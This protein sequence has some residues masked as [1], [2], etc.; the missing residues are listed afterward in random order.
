MSAFADF[1]DL[2]TAVIEHVGRPDIAEVFPRLVLLAEAGFNRRLRLRDQITSTSVT[3]SSGSAALPSDYL[4]AIGLY[5]SNGL[6]YIQ[7]PIQNVKDTATKTKSYYA[8]N[9][10]NIVTKAADGAKTFEYY[11]KVPTLT[12]GGMTDTNWLLTKYPTI[13]LYGVGAEAA[14]FARDVDLARVTVELLEMAI[15]EA[16]ADDSRSRYSRARVR[17]PGIAP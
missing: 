6:E 3:I 10:S 5:D 7:Q 13:Y 15:S 4:E 9:G 12:D 2:R 1:L 8:I 14:K 17:I 11:A 16:E